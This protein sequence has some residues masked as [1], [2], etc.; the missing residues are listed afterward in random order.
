MRQLPADKYNVA[1]FKLAEFVVRGEKERAL[2]L[3]RL[4]V[5][6]FDDAALAYQ[7]E[8][9][10]LLSFHD[11]TA[12]Q[13]KYAQAAQKYSQEQRFIESAAVYEHLIVLDAECQ[14]YY[15]QLL[16]L[17]KKLKY[18]TRLLVVLKQVGEFL[19]KKDRSDDCIAII[20]EYETCLKS[21]QQADLYGCFTLLL[22]KHTNSQEK[23]EFFL[24]KTAELLLASDD[25][26]QIPTFLMN[27]DALNSNYYQKVV[28]YLKD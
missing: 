14:L 16:M 24:E 23:I 28:R 25:S 9:D 22:V 4:L 18:D 19:V 21:Q 2:G 1:W 11:R 17:Y 5:H 26:Q 3:Y 10:L 7:L 12:A 15:Q 27:L 13:E 8:G 20:E 6:S